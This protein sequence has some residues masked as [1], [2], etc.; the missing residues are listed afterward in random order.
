MHSVNNTPYKKSVSG[1]EVLCV[2]MCCVP[3]LMNFAS[4]YNFVF[5]FFFND[6]FE[7]PLILQ[8]TLQYVLDCG[9]IIAFIVRIFIGAKSQN[10]YLNNL[11][12]VLYV[13][14]LAYRIILII[15]SFSLS[16]ESAPYESLYLNS[17]INLLLLFAAA[18]LYIAVI[19]IDKLQAHKTTIFTLLII[20][21]LAQFL[22]SLFGIEAMYFL[23]LFGPSYI[24]SIAINVVQ[25]FIMIFAFVI[26]IYVDN[27]K[28]PSFNYSQHP[29]YFQ[30]PYPQQQAQYQ[31]P[32]QYQYQQQNSVQFQQPQNMQQPPAQFTPPDV[33]S[34]PARNYEQ[35]L[36]NLK[37]DYKNG[38]L[39]KDDYERIRCEILSSKQ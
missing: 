7:L 3:L 38:L 28:A 26:F 2:V 25:S 20:H 6:Y 35:E 12:L 17:I 37:Q 39:P 18:A 19:H 22:Y 23:D 8:I 4:L 14:H 9:A 5:G 16:S 13:V 29:P 24:I 27:I 15:D 10:R 1:L 34:A 31:Q 21:T 33:Y 30:Q 36:K 11:Y 32:P